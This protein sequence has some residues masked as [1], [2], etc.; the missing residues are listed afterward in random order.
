MEIPVLRNEPRMTSKR[1]YEYRREIERLS[2]LDKETTLKVQHQLNVMDAKEKELEIKC[3]TKL[4]DSENYEIEFDKENYFVRIFIFD[5]KK[6]KVYTCSL[7]GEYFEKMEYDC[8][9]P[10]P[11]EVRERG[12]ENIFTGDN[13][14]YWETYE[15][16]EVFYNN[17]LKIHIN[18]K[19]Y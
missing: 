8:P 14:D 17:I 10:N 2:Q 7:W 18:I 16:F 5:D 9:S 11:T 4:L 13:S 12:V 3:R 15:V 1:F 6:E 19:D